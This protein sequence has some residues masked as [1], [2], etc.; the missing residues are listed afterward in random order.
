M[1]NTTVYH[2]HCVH[3]DRTHTG[4][5][6]TMKSLLQPG[7]RVVVMF[8]A[9]QS[10]YELAQSVGCEVDLWEP[11]VADSGRLEFRVQDVLVRERGWVGEV[12]E[13]ASELCMEQ[14]HSGIQKSS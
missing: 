13:Q 1:H 14:Q 12:G 9:Y 6:L 3:N 11:H 4:V 2:P 10:L 7:Q 8:P 5:Y